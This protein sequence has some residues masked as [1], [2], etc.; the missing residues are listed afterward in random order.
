M[1]TILEF[2]RAEVNAMKQI[3]SANHMLY[4]TYAPNIFQDC[5][6]MILSQD[7]KK[8]NFSILPLLS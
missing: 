4:L 1:E 8:E 7:A 2:S 3:I 5:F 6:H